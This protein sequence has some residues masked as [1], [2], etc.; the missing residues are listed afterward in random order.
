M[1]KR[2]LAEGCEWEVRIC[3]REEP[4]AGAAPGDEDILEFHCVDALRPPRRIAV[5]AD[6][7]SAL[8]EAAL[9]SA[10][11]HALPIAA[12]HYGRPGKVMLDTGP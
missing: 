10:F 11:L 5:R 12:D 7:T 2:I 4:S 1:W 8:D 3:A 6:T 9:R